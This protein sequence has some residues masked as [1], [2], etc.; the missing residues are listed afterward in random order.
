MTLDTG[1]ELLQNDRMPLDI[2]GT[3]SLN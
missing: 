1:I 3:A 2:K